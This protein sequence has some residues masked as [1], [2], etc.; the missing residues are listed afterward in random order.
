MKNVHSYEAVTK[1]YTRSAA[2]VLDEL[3]SEIAKE[4]VWMLPALATFVEPPPIP[5][6]MVAV[7]NEEQETWELMAAVAAEALAAGHVPSFDEQKSEALRLV[8]QSIDLIYAAV[9]GN[10]A[11]EYLMAEEEAIMYLAALAE[12]DGADVTVPDSVQS[13]ADAFNR[14]PEEAAAAILMQAAAWRTASAAMRRERLAM[15]ASI[16]NAGTPQD[17]ASLSTDWNA[18]LADFHAELGV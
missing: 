6:G 10:R 16:R 3:E 18:T 5:E 8:D 7:F 15:K 13:D 11:Q 1:I 12:D 14:T 17:L 2:A 4:D 9:I